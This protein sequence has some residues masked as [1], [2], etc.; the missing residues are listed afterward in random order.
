MQASGPEQPGSPPHLDTV[1]LGTGRLPAASPLASHTVWSA[2]LSGALAMSLWPLPASL[3]PWEGRIRGLRSNSSFSSVDSKLPTKDPLALPTSEKKNGSPGQ[4]L[5]CAALCS[6]L[7]LVS[8]FQDPAQQMVQPLS[9]LLIPGLVSVRVSIS[10]V[11]VW[12]WAVDGWWAVV[13]EG[14]GISV[15]LALCVQ[16]EAAQFGR[17]PVEREGSGVQRRLC[18]Q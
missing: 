14:S 13:A 12:A 8:V 2:I 1:S 15:V 9:D 16:G 6:P 5:R 10:E 11:K 7:Q 18:A 3:D 17:A 4:L